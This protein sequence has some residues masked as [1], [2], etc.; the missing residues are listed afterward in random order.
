MAVHSNN[1][2]TFNYMGFFFTFRVDVGMRV[3]ISALILDHV[4]M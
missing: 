4:L 1:T 2:L 3:F